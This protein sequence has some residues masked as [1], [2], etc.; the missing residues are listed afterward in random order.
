MSRYELPAIGSC[1]D[2]WRLCKSPAFEPTA[3]QRLVMESAERA[4]DAGLFYTV[5]VN[6]AV[7]KDL[8]VTTEQLGRNTERVDGGDFAYDVFYAR[9]AIEAIRYQRP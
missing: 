2:Q 9:S 7:A 4:L 8:G 3:R 5:D 1:Y 6:A